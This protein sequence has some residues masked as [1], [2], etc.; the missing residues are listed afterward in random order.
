MIRS[1][2][3]GCLAA[4]ALPLLSYASS[5]REA[6][7]IAGLPRLDATDLYVFRSYESGREDY[8]TLIANYI[9]FQGPFGG[10]NFYHLDP[11]AIYAIN[12]DNNGNAQADISFQF[13]FKN[14]QR[15]LTVNAGGKNVAVPLLNIGPVSSSDNQSLNVVESYTLSVSRSGSG[16][17]LAENETLGGTVFYKPVDNI[18]EKS[19]ANYPAYAD[20]FI[21]SVKIPDCGKPGRVFV[22]QRKD[23][24]FV[25]LGE[26]FDLVNINPVGP[27]NGQHNSLTH[28]NVT[29]LALEVPIECLTSGTDP[30]IGAWTTSSAPKVMGNDGDNDADDFVQKSRLGSPL[31]NEVII[32]LPD[33]DAFNASAPTNDAQFLR[34]V[35]NPT[36]PVLLNVLFGGAAN[37]PGTPRDDLVAAFLT[38]V[39][40]LNQ[41]ARVTPAELLRL[42]TSIAATAPAMQNDLGVLGGDLAGFPNGRRPYDDVVD[43]ELRVAEGALCGAIGPCGGETSDPNH[44][45]PYTDQVEAA[46]PD[47]AHLRTAGS[48]D[49][50][51]TFL[52]AFPYLSTPLPGSPNGPNGIPA[53]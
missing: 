26:I 49:P 47:A 44:G 48:E 18:G 51:D 29:A 42:N 9:P 17:A 37:V 2:A 36:L 22:G 4:A 5:H 10:P 1:V 52:S 3:L 8:V 6:P 27:R 12:V 53:P 7:E 31:I 50:S 15:N 23:P 14:T 43:I 39:K 32:G 19:I 28:F 33:K 13:R 41:P 46:G 34:Y 35:T 38:G 40:G 21:Y 16:S 45:N 30:V 11:N 24:F 25:N 20:S